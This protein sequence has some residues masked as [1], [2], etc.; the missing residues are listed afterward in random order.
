MKLLHPIYTLTNP[1]RPV[2]RVTFVILALV[3]CVLDQLSKMIVVLYLEE[4]VPVPLVPGLLDLRHVVNTGAAWSIAS[5]HTGMLAGFSVLIS[6]V[7]AVMAWRFGPAEQ[8]LRIG[9]GLILGG[10]VGN[11]IDRVRLGYVVDFI[12]AHWFDK[13]HW[14]IFNVADSA[15][16][17]GIGLWLLASFRYAPREKTAGSS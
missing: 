2:S 10:A 12:D 16:C 3:T 8:G 15:I 9:L 4:S 6:V 14:P 17:I 5:G 7:I 13:A 1:T 11:L